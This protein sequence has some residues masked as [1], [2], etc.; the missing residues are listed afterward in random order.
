MKIEKITIKNWRSIKDQVIYAQDLMVIIGQNNHG[1]SNLL[2]SILFFFGE[3]KHHDLDFHK[4]STELFV[5]LQFGCLDESDNTTF[6]KY[7]TSEGKVV[8]RKTA[9]L[10]GSFEYRGYIENPTEEWLQEVNASAY[11]KRELASSLPFHPFL[12]ATGRISKQDIVDAQAAY[13]EQNRD[14]INFSYELEATNFLGLKSVASGI[15]GEVYFI[16]AVKEASDDFT[17]KDSSVFG[18]MYSDVVALMSDSND[19]WKTTKEN[20]GKLFA[21]LN[22]KDK[23]GNVNEG[24]PKQLSDFEEE[25]ATE[26]V[27]WGARVDI[28]VSSPDIES[29]F[30]ANTQVWVDDGVRTDIKRKGHGLQRA[31][32]VA[33]IQVVAKRAIAAAANNGDEGEGARKVSNS[34][35]FIF[36][37]PELYLHPQAQRS[38]F[39]SFVNLSESG[40]QVIL[41]THS[42][43]LIDVE[44]YKSIYIATK[45]TGSDETTVKQCVD[46]LFEDD[47]K[48]DFNL[49]YWINPDRGEL[50][51]AS[52][53][54]LL[55]GATEKTVFPLLAKKIGVFRYDYTLI[56][57]GSKDN[58]PLYVKLLNKFKIPYVA[59]YDRDHQQG[60]GADAIASAKTST[61]KIED[62]IDPAVGKSLVL[63]NDIEEELGLPKGGSSKPYIALNHITSQGFTLSE[64]MKQKI[65]LVYGIEVEA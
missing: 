24:R 25:L 7:L 31:L 29:V 6:K 45:E 59:V 12:P 42:S 53:V 9:Y 33:L 10:G 52:K 48:K 35:Y 36:E 57:C 1:K 22:K 4:G 20:L 49:S 37:E 51:F 46:D 39:D 23:D 54:V 13:I 16:P 30:K 3:I 65:S 17:S 47:A 14:A 44:R 11:T 38:L 56:D 41:C 55:E 5:E 63:V 28:E 61:Q 27:T 58:I 62:V 40:S 60:K 43:G 2:S 15:F 34:R 8:V 32:T 19:E 26:L 18:K 50:F 21:T 64:G